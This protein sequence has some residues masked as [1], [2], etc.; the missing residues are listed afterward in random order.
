MQRMESLPNCLHIEPLVVM[1]LL[2]SVTAL[3]WKPGWLA[4]VYS[5]IFQQ[6]LTLSMMGRAIN[7][8]SC[9]PFNRHTKMD[10]SN[11]HE[12]IANETTPLVPAKGSKKP[13]TPLPKLQI[14]I[15]ITLQLAEPIASTSIFPYINQ[16]VRELG[17]TGGDDA[18]VGYYA[19]M[20]VGVRITTR[21]LHARV[22]P[23]SDVIGRSLCFSSDKH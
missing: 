11:S 13:K 2:A 3:Y 22:V 4:P 8:G 6:K 20:I 18:A 9:W 5:P 1:L 23:S 12:I 16:L 14:G 17:I 15:L 21:E 19:G 10:T 7:T